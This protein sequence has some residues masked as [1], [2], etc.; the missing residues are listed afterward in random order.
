MRNIHTM[1]ANR[2]PVKGDILLRHIWKNNPNECISWWRYNETID[3]DSVKQ[4][5]TL[6]G[7]FRDMYQSFEVRNLYITINGS[8]SRDE[9]VTDGIEV[10]KATPKLVDAQ[11]LLD[12]REWKKIALTTD[13]D[14]IAER[15]K[16]ASDEFLDWFVK[17]PNCETVVVRQRP[18]VNAVVKGKG[19]GYFANG[20]D[21][22]IPKKLVQIDQDNPVTRG[23]TALVYKQ[24]TQQKQ[25]PIPELT[26]LIMMVSMDGKN[27]KKR[28]V[29]ALSKGIYVTSAGIKTCAHT[30]E[31]FTAIDYWRFAKPI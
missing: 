29:I 14:L 26:N 16:S 4:Y 3:I 13:P 21:I 15:V 10:I 2:E 8:F 1:K 23:S 6:N 27:W 7:S 5:T 30:D 25:E 24:E 31:E 17:N 20:Y 22:I 19:I 28:N 18:K 12:R 11:G 9:Y